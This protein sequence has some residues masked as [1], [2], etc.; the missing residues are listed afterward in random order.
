MER[1]IQMEIFQKKVTPFEVFPFS[2]H[3]TETTEI[4]WTIY[5]V[6]QCQASSWGGRWLIVLTQAHP[7][8]GVL[9]MVQ[10]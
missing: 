2:R 7:L 10:L 1:F 5:L 6:N 3:F 8:F 4:F 9:Q